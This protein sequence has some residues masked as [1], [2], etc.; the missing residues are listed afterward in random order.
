MK[1]IGIKFGLFYGLGSLLLM[2][3]AYFTNPKI[4]FTFAD[5]QTLLSTILLITLMYLAA[6]MT[7][8]NKGGYISF[9]EAFVP[10]FLTYIIGTVIYSFAAFAL[11]AYDTDLR[12]MIVEVN[13]DNMIWMYNM[14]GM[15]EDQI[16]EATELVEEQMEDQNPYT[17]ANTFIGLLTSTLFVGLPL[18]AI[19][20][21]IVK[22]KQP[23]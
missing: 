14:M 12:T 5:W 16:L 23:V 7:R 15:S 21:A 3:I 2:S 10:A 13:E 22:K 17:I 6:K 11:M 8:D 20:A 18:S 9:G 1:N 4:I 19:I